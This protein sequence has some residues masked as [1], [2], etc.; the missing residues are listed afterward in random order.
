[1]SGSPTIGLHRRARHGGDGGADDDG[2]E[3]ESV[4]VAAVQRVGGASRRFS[5]RV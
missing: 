1:M 4:K 2:G 5:A 3:R